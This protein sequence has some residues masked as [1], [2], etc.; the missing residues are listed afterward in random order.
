MEDVSIVLSPG[1]VAVIDHYTT[2]RPSSPPDVNATRRSVRMS[3]EHVRA[4]NFRS[5]I[6]KRRLM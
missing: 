1:R 2:W 6:F 4:R 5:V 3:S